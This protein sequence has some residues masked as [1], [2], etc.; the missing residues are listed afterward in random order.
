M[1]TILILLFLFGL[2]LSQTTDRYYTIFQQGF[3]KSDSTLVKSLDFTTNKWTQLI[4]KGANLELNFPSNYDT[5][6]YYMEWKAYIFIQKF[7]SLGDPTV[8]QRLDRT[9]KF[10]ERKNMVIEGLGPIE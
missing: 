1:K 9:A 5:S 8:T 3:K 7:D 10:I 6:K 2:A 4:S